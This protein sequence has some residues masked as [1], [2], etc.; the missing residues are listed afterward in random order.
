MLVNHFTHVIY[1][2]P[3][4][5]CQTLTVCMVLIPGEHYGE[6]FGKI[7]MLRKVP[8]IRDGEFCLAER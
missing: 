5:C 4:H 7:N 6:E 2:L 3:T 1:A 8:A